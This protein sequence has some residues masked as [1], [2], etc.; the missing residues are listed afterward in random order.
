M[1]TSVLLGGLDGAQTILVL[2]GI[3]AW[4][5]WVPPHDQT[6]LGASSLQEGSWEFLLLFPCPNSAHMENVMLPNVSKDV[7]R[8]CSI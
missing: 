7:F 2:F 6:A 3:I 8:K 5:L 4:M 1:Q